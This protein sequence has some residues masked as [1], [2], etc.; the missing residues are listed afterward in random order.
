MAAPALTPDA[1][2]GALVT[3]LTGVGTLGLVTNRTPDTPF[4][5]DTPV[6]VIRPIQNVHGHMAGSV[7]VAGAKF[8]QGILEL[9]YRDAPLAQQQDAHPDRTQ[10]QI[11]DALVANRDAIVAAIDADRT[12]SGAVTNIGED[13]GIAE[14]YNPDGYTVEW[15]A[16]TWIGVDLLIP[17]LGPKQNLS[18]L[19]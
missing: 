12:L 1:I 8:D 7:R 19:T 13:Q 14:A 9:R 4:Q 16:A 18:R 2:A 5:G 10:A 15:D 6:V 11:E 17:Y 3:L